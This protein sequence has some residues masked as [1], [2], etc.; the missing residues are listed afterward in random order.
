MNRIAIPVAL[1]ALVVLAG[2]SGAAERSADSRPAT[3]DSSGTPAPGITRMSQET[4]ETEVVGTVIY[5][6][7]QGGYFAVAD[8][9]P[10]G[11]VDA[12]ARILAILVHG[13]GSMRGEDVAP[14]VG[15]YCRF[16]GSTVESS[17]PTYSAPLLTFNTYHILSLPEPVEV[18]E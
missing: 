11:E 10:G 6:R 2:C 5:R 16:I 18:E 17:S 9:V 4:S 13:D 1:L 8:L 3:I 14:L 12:N 15:A 7:E